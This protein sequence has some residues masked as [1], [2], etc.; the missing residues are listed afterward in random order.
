MEAKKR[1][2]MGSQLSAISKQENGKRLSS[3]SE[4]SEEHESNQAK[5]SE[6]NSSLNSESEESKR[7]EL[8]GDIQMSPIKACPKLSESVE[9]KNT[10]NFVAELV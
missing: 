6:H 7:K 4:R 1:F 9:E 8:G 2:L 3:A 10:P 5:E